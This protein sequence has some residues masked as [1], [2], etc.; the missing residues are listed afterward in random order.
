MEWMFVLTFSGWKFMGTYK[1]T[2]DVRDAVIEATL[3]GTSWDK[4]I[5][6]PVQQAHNLGYECPKACVE[7]LDH[8]GRLVHEVA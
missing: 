8:Y 4:I 1:G 5:W 2:N 7:T 6:M 3:R